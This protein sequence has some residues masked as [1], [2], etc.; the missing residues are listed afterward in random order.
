MSRELGVHS[1]DGRLLVQCWVAEL[2]QLTPLA[3]GS[4][5]LAQLP[6]PPPSGDG[7]RLRFWGTLLHENLIVEGYDNRRY[8]GSQTSGSLGNDLIM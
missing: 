3:L 5:L 7:N 1:R 8:K 4:R 2:Q 6:M